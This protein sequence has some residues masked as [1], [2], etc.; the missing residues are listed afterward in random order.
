MNTNFYKVA[1]KDRTAKVE[2]TSL[3]MA[4]AQFKKL[5]AKRLA[6]VQQ[7]FDSFGVFVVCDEQMNETHEFIS[8]WRTS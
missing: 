4:A 2:S 3:E 8:V 6:W 7:D 1:N 5:P